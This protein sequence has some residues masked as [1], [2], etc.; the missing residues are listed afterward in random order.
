MVEKQKPFSV[1][2][3]VVAGPHGK[4]TVE[5]I[6]DPRVSV[7]VMFDSGIQ[8]WF[9]SCGRW[10]K[11]DPEP[12]IYHVNTGVVTIDTTELPEW[13]V[14]KPIWVRNVPSDDWIPRHF[15]K[16]ENGKV[17]A[18][19]AGKTSHSTYGSYFGWRFSRDTDPAEDVD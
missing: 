10:H 6:D 8:I 13:E 18:Y 7:L 19:E 15:C 3:R 17:C 2:D 16:H 12:T 4:G 1:R 11:K 9:N 5:Q 14:D